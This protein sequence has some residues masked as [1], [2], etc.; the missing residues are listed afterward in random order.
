MFGKKLVFGLILT[1]SLIA[2]EV[3]RVRSCR[4]AACFSPIITSAPDCIQKLST[5]GFQSATEADEKA[6]PDLEVNASQMIGDWPDIRTQVCGE[7]LSGGSGAEGI[8][9]LASSRRAVPPD[10][11]GRP[12]P[13]LARQSRIW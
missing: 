10:R 5:A 11:A 7:G 12:G 8:G 9:T 3:D 1:G 2:D 6:C 4:R 13:A